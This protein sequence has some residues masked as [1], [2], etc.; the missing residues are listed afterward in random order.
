MVTIAPSKD[1][2]IILYTDNPDWDI[3]KTSVSTPR[4]TKSLEKY[5]VDVSDPDPVLDNP[6]SI[7]DPTITSGVSESRKHPMTGKMEKH[8]GIDEASK[9]R[10][11]AGIENTVLEAPAGGKVLRTG[12]EERAGNK[13]VVSHGR[14][15]ESKFF[16]AA[17]SFVKPG[18]YFTRNQLRGA[19]RTPLGIVGNTGRSKGAHIHWEYRVNG[20]VV[21]PNT[22]LRVEMEY[23]SGTK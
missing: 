6:A 2:K 22:Q 13:I 20:K 8:P 11:S 1:T 4:G 14:G 3:K 19:G 5:T 23:K 21:D 12:L 17:D 16:H 9:A 7:E 15:R 18:Q 10:G